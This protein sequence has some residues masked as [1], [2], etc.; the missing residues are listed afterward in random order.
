MGL[1]MTQMSASYISRKEATP[2][3]AQGTIPCCQ[4][5]TQMTLQRAPHELQEQ[6]TPPLNGA[7][8]SFCAYTLA[9]KTPSNL[10]QPSGGEQQKTGQMDEAAG[11]GVWRRVE[12]R[13][14]KKTHGLGKSR[15]K[16]VRVILW[17]SFQGTR[18][19]LA[20]PL[21]DDLNSTYKVGP[22]GQGLNPLRKGLGNPFKRDQC[23]LQLW[24]CLC[25]QEAGFV[26]EREGSG[27]P[28][29][30]ERLKDKAGGRSPAAPRT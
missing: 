28:G 7:N 8:T 27:H 29:Q 16:P 18:Q 22:V 2:R 5:Q 25:V 3:W 21:A 20:K 19:N 23:L 1:P 11:P 24:K 6:Y 30:G 15:K 9:S 10:A 4:K 26:L 14:R 17:D 13:S 12:S